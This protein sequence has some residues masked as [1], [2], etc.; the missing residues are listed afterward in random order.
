MY[1]TMRTAITIFRRINYDMEI[2]EESGNK[3]VVFPVNFR[4]RMNHALIEQFI[5][6]KSILYN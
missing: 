2:N 4:G 3:I 5:S 6:I 1:V